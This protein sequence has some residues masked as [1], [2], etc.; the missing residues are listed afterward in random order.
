M[1]DELTEWETWHQSL[2]VAMEECRAEHRELR[3]VLYERKAK[4]SRLAQD[5]AGVVP[6]SNHNHVV[7]QMSYGY[8]KLRGMQEDRLLTLQQRWCQAHGE[9]LVQLESEACQREQE[10]HEH[11]L[12]A[13]ELA[14]VMRL[15]SIEHRRGEFLEKHVEDQ[16]KVWPRLVE[17]QTQVEEY[18]QLATIYCDE[19]HAASEIVEALRAESSVWERRV[20]EESTVV[21]NGPRHAFQARAMPPMSLQAWPIL[22]ANGHTNDSN[23]N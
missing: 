6:F 11:R 13:E 20:H 7:E 12:N 14:T 19:L 10:L 21:A 15:T 4:N 23:G 18:R 3:K 17:Q 2:E 5:L 9:S 8:S 22:H 16:A 1:R